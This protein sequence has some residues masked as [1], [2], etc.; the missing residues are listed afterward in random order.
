MLH[1]VQKQVSTLVCHYVLRA[2]LIFLK[3]QLPCE[4]YAMRSLMVEPI[5]GFGIKRSSLK[6]SN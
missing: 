1:K 4:N 6:G 3:V 2:V 5:L